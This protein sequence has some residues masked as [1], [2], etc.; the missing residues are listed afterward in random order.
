MLVILSQ[1]IDTP[2]SY[3]DE[4]FSVYHYP[5]RYKNQLHTGDTFVYYQG[6]RYDTEQ[7]YYF[8]TGMIG[9]IYCADEDNY[10][11]KLICCRKFEKKV[12]IYLPGEGYIEQLDYESVRKS[13]NPPWQSSVRALSDK[14]YQYILSCAGS[15]VSPRGGYSAEELD[16]KLKKA[17]RRYYV[18]KE[19]TAILE[20]E[21]IAGEIA[22]VRAVRKESDELVYLRQTNEENA[23]EIKKGR[24]SRIKDLLVYCKEMKMSYSY[25]PLLVLA[26]LDSEKPGRITIGDAAVFFKDY[27]DGRRKN[28]KIVE[29]KKCIY[30]NPEASTRS[31]EAN[32]IANPVKALEES[33]FFVYN[34]EKRV[35]SLIPGLW[36]KMTPDERAALRLTCWNK[37]NE[38]YAE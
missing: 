37:L 12:P 28:G 5:S 36:A 27:Y 35:F 19:D 25:K 23:D 16:E 33:G 22:N 11:A 9:E 1:K 7:R 6:N 20:I 3:E 31:I 17:I 30:L 26:L 34:C 38:Y 14:A 15:L 4:L 24:K 2:S 10:Y 8:G 29:K 32:I 21:Q 18:E 13:G